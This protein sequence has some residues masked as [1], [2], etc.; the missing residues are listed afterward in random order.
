MKN[1]I[2]RITTARTASILLMTLCV[3][4]LSAQE[5]SIDPVKNLHLQDVAPPAPPRQ[6]GDEAY[7]GRTPDAT[8]TPSQNAGNVIAVLEI[9]VLD[10]DVDRTAT[11]DRAELP[12]ELSVQDSYPN[13][14]H[15]SATIIYHLP[16]QA[17]VYAEVF[18]MLGRVVY[19]SQTQK[20]NAGWDHTLSLNLPATS[21]G[22]YVYRINVE[23]ESGTLTRTGQMV[24]VR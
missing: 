9:T 20:V 22:L 10:D 18:D 21:S 4:T 14:F 24:Q 13:P 23:I 17:Q 2:K 5:W 3:T 16:E 11:E 1:N 19:T 7:S 8:H 15:T 6:P 12:Q